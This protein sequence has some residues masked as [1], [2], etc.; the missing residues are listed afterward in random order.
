[1]EALEEEIEVASVD[2]V[3]I[4]NEEEEVVVVVVVVVIG[5]LADVTELKLY[6]G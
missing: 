6:I 5:S 2:E 1:M 3:I 4:D